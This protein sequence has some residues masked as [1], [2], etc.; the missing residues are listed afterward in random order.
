VYDGSEA[1]KQADLR[2]ISKRHAI[3]IRL[4]AQ[5]QSQDGRHDGQPRNGYERRGASLDP[6]DRGM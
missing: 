3:R 4:D 5:A 2:A 1:T 6:A